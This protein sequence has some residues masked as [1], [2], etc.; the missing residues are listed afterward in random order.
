[1]AL[2]SVRRLYPS[3]TLGRV[4]QSALCARA[5]AADCDKVCHLTPMRRGLS[6]MSK[7]IWFPLWL[8]IQSL[9][10]RVMHGEGIQVAQRPRLKVG[11][12][13]LLYTLHSGL[14]VLRKVRACTERESQL[15]VV[16]DHTLQA[17]RRH[18]GGDRSNFVHCDSKSWQRSQRQCLCRSRPFL[19][20]IPVGLIRR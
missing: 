16:H 1:M 13:S 18:R 17:A 19:M 20:S 15:H 2:P 5:G 9:S 8:E 14:F 10:C 4:R 6:G 11:G 7:L 3:F 12:G